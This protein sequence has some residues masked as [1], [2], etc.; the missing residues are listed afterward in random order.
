MTFKISKRLH[1]I[2]Q[3]DKENHLIQFIIGS[4]SDVFSYKDIRSCSLVYEDAKAHGVEK[5]FNK[6]IVV[7]VMQPEVLFTKYVYVGVKVE[8]VN[9]EEHYGYVLDEKLPVDTLD[10]YKY[11]KIAQDVVD[12]LKEQAHTS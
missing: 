9:G 4:P 8:L 5:P 3:V 2:A 12:V 1:E 6:K 7:G 11:K 10:F